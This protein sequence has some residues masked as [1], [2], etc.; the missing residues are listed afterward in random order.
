MR[1]EFAS[2]AEIP[3][4]FW[5]WPHIDPAREWADRMSGQIVVDD[6]FMD[7]FERLRREVDFTLP[8]SSG[9]RTPEH[10]LVVSTTGDDGPHTTARAADVKVYGARAMVVVE[11]A[12]RLGFTGIGISQKG[13]HASR[14]V[15]LDILK[16]PQY[17]RPSMWSY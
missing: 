17:P 12:I 5:R 8:I 13:S 1:H 7:L 4:G 9:Y 3:A 11:A 14:F 6:A 2:A 10:N 15:H 16:A